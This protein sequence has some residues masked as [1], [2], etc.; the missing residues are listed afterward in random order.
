MGRAVPV[1]ADNIN[2]V[3][4]AICA[5]AKHDLYQLRNAVKRLDAGTD[6]CAKFSLVPKIVAALSGLIHKA[7][8]IFCTPS[9]FTINKI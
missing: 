6:S 3:V 7:L 4:G 1:L 2:V 8:S 9:P 5:L